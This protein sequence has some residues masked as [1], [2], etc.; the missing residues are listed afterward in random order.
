[1]RVD[2]S[3]LLCVEL[4]LAASADRVA[5]GDVLSASMLNVIEGLQQTEGVIFARHPSTSD[6]IDRLNR[7][8]HDLRQARKERDEAQAAN[9]LLV[10]RLAD[11]AVGGAAPI[12][13]DSPSPNRGTGQPEVSYEQH[14]LDVDDVNMKWVSAA[15]R[16]ETFRLGAVAERTRLRM[17]ILCDADMLKERSEGIPGGTPK[18]ARVAVLY[19]VLGFL[20]ACPAPECA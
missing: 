8:Q 2:A 5:I 16:S 9:R 11:Q 1:V 12:Q 4:E 10:S 19:E 14:S 18:A 3:Y 17:R 20:E 6:P 15:M 7:S 13:S